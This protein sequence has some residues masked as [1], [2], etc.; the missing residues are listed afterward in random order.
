ML[1]LGRV[2]AISLEQ[3]EPL[4]L[5]VKSYWDNDQ[6]SGFVRAIEQQL[7][8]QSSVHDYVL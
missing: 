8:G 2:G 6:H 7:A 5:S 4:L 1:M 3:L